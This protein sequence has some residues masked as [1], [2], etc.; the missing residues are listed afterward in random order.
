MNSGFKADDY[1]KSRVTG[2][3]DIGVVGHRSLGERY[4]RYIY[5]RRVNVINNLIDKLGAEIKHARILDIGCGSGFYADYWYAKGAT[6]YAGVDVSED[7]INRL[8]QKYSSYKFINA[9]I[10]LIQDEFLKG[11]FDIVTVFDV[12][13]HIVDETAFEKAVSNISSLL[14]PDG[15]LIIFDQLCRHKYSLTPHVVFRNRLEYI[16]SFSEQGLKLVETT[17]LF[18]LLVPPL[19]GVKLLDI[20]IAGI[21]KLLG[22]VLKKSTVLSDLLGRFLLSI[23]RLLLKLPVNFPNNDAFIFRKQK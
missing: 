11:S 18:Q 8:T 12:F 1:W 7:S 2:D 13:Y 5:Q 15:H 22:I 3:L 10:S 21:Y 19:F 23:D 9:D 4:N 6:E 16:N 17:R 20:A 14:K